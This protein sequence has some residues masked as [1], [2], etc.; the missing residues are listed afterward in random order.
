MWTISLPIHLL[1]LHNLSSLIPRNSRNDGGSNKQKE[2]EIK[3]AELQLK[4]QKIQQEY[5]KLAVDS[6]LK[7][8]RTNL[9]RGTK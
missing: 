8:T 9:E 5:E 6:S 7:A 2:L 1:Y 3:A 4:A